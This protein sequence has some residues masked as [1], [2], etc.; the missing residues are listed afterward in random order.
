[1]KL[2][3]SL[4]MLVQPQV[5]TT[6]SPWTFPQ[7]ATRADWEARA[8]AMRQEILF[9][10]G[11]W[12]M[13]PRGALNAQIFGRIDKNGYSVEKVY[14]ESV[15]GFFVTGNLYRPRTNAAGPFPTVLAP[16]GHGAYGRLIADDRF[17]E[18]ARAAS[19]AR[20]GYVVFTYDMV[21]Q[22]DSFQVPHDWAQPEGQLWSFSVLGLQLW[23]SIRAL[24]FLE[25]LADVD[26]NRIGASGASGGGTQTFL[27][28][29]VD[30]RVN[31]S[32]P[33]NMV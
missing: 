3:L 17:N 23:N 6:D 31:V 11:L 32:I 14:F 30:D 21:G 20:Q 28:T 22:N 2:L 25:S 7:A 1:M 27:V 4:L 29:A 24:D 8:T 5:R 13:P 33:A 15:P 16:H 10:A 12:P 19:L 18:P 9:H 26:R